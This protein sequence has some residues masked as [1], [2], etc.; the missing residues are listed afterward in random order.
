MVVGSTTMPTEAS[1][2]GG[3]DDV[4]RALGV[5]LGQEAVAPLD[6][7][8]GVAAVEAVVPFVVG[9]VEARHRV[10]SAHDRRHQL[11]GS[12]SPGR[13][14]DPAQGL[15]ADN[16]LLLPHRRLA[17]LTG[18]Q[19][20][21]GSVHP[22]REHLDEEFTLGGNRIGQLHEP[23]AVAFPGC[24][25]D[26]LHQISSVWPVRLSGSPRDERPHTRLAS[27]YADGF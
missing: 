9:A 5:V 27:R 19:L 18:D 25:N 11:S 7:A 1:S 2:S 6:A 24:D 14:A 17:V 22:H 16:Q 26:G 10:G 13:F 15:V 8:F 4:L 12:Q 23:V 3:G 20:V 21:V